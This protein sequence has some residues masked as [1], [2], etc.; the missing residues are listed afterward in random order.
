MENVMTRTVYLPQVA[1][2]NTPRLMDAAGEG[3]I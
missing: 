2:A 1:E 3:S